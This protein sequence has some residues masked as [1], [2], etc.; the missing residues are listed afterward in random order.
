MSFK[1][2]PE[3]SS[4]TKGLGK[5]IEMVEELRNERS[6]DNLFAGIFNGNPPFDQVFSD[7]PEP[8][9][10]EIRRRDKLIGELT[11]FLIRKVDPYLIDSTSSVPMEVFEEMSRLG[12]YGIK[13]PE[14]WGGRGLS[15][16]SYVEALSVA[17]SWCSAI[18]IVLSADNTI[19]C[20]FPV[21]YYG[22]DEQKDDFLPELVKWPTGFCLT[23]K[24]VGSDAS[25]IRTYAKRVRREGLAGYEITGEKWFTTN[26]ILENGRP[27]A[28]YLAVVAR[29]VNHSDE[30]NDANRKACYG[31]FIVPTDANGVDIGT[32][33]H[34]VGMRGIHNSNPRFNKVLVPTFNLIGGEGAGLKI[35]FESL[36]TGRIAIAKGCIGVSKQAL[37]ISRW[38]ANKRSQL[39]GPLIQKE[40]VRDK[41]VY[42][43]TTIL[44]MEA[45]TNYACVAFDSGQDVRLESAAAKTFAAEKA[46]QIVDNMMQIRGGRGYETWQ[47]LSRRELTPPDELMWTGARPN[48]I[49]EG[50]NEIMVQFIFRE[51][52]DRYIK[53]GLPLISK[54]SSM[55]EKFGAIMKMAGYYAGTFVSRNIPSANKRLMIHLEYVNTRSAQLARKIITKSAKYQA[56]LAQKQLML[57]RFSRIAINLGAMALACAY[58]GKLDKE[59]NVQE[60][61]Y[62]EL[63]DV[64]CRTTTAEVDDLFKGLDRN[65]DEYR[66]K[67][68]KRLVVGDFDGFLLKGIIPM[69][70]AYMRG[71]DHRA[72]YNCQ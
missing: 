9:A 70:E 61:N 11:D 20:K 64:F 43:A 4:I 2:G 33:N 27:L 45:M 13:V 16:T 31:L 55:A 5:G 56:K 50:A 53:T 67:V 59:D 21:M 1:D 18:V 15:Q 10:E 46:W 32:R 47:S 30:L 44:A 69:T 17:A 40:L 54:S 62:V 26:G 35:A 57:D 36:N 19:G 28:K 25:N 3:N 24:N 51:G 7:W 52:T 65:D 6:A 8:S 68:S 72:E 29:I 41:L 38:W 34:F 23:E 63:A 60:A 48:R 37:N 39:G 66:Y 49:F 22:T 42:A 71:P 14:N 58:A 12:L